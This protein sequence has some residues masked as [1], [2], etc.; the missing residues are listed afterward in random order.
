MYPQIE[1][2]ECSSPLPAQTEV[3]IIGGGIV[4]VCCAWWLDRKSTRL[5]SSHSSDRLTSRMP[6]SA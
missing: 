4:G 3:A 2:L 6:S 1:H 5:N